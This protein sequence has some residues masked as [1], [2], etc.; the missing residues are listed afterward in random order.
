MERTYWVYILA[1]RKNGTL[2]VGVTSDLG[3]RIYAHREGLVPGFTRQYGIKLLLL[4]LCP[5]LTAGWKIHL[6]FD[7]CF[8]TYLMLLPCIRKIERLQ[9][10]NADR[11]Q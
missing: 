8:S 5:C 9:L 3:A 7:L 6:E 11:R 4:S 1:S 10:Y 2:Y